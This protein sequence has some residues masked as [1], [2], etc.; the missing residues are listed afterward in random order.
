MTARRTLLAALVGFAFLGIARAEDAALRERLEKMLVE[1][2]E[3]AR[4]STESETTYAALCSASERA[5]E[6][7]EPEGGA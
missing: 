3:I 4:V 5:Y 7:S 6:L 1:Q 2:E